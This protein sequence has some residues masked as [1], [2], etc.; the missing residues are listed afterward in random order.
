[1]AQPTFA[2]PDDYLR[3]FDQPTRQWQYL[4][5]VE[6]EGPILY[7]FRFAALAPGS[8]QAQGTIFSDLAPDKDSSHIYQAFLGLYPETWYNISHPYNIRRL[9]LDERVSLISEDIVSL[10]R[11]ED[12]PYDLPTYSLWLDENRFPAI[13]PRNVGR[14]TFTPKIEFLLMKFRVEFDNDLGSDVKGKLQSGDIPS[15]PINF[16]GEI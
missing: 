4:H 16:G 7:P 13:Q 1:M 12:S 9:S 3:F 14:T 5:L 6:A 10:L 15:T 11:Y 2:L 8:E